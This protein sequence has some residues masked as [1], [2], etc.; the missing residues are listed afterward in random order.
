MVIQQQELYLL[1]IPLY[2]LCTL[3]SLLF[4]LKELFSPNL[5]LIKYSIIYAESFMT[6]VNLLLLQD[7]SGSQTFVSLF[8]ESVLR[9][10]TVYQRCW[11]LRFNQTY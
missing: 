10:T 2:I 9:T 6:S 1:R 5:T 8:R 3:M 11:R 4:K 7:F